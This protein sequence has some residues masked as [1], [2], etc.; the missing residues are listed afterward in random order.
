[1]RSVRRAIAAV[2]AFIC[3]SATA[4]ADSGPVIVIP[5]RG[6]SIEG[7]EG[8]Y[9]AG[10]VVFGDWGLFRPGHIAPRFE[11][12]AVIAGPLR[13]TGW[14]PSSGRRPAIGRHEREPSPDAP[15]PQAAESYRRYWGIGSQ[16]AGPAAT[17]T[18]EGP[19]VIVAPSEV[20]H[21]RPHPPAPVPIKP[22]V[23][24]P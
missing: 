15:K 14:Y 10:A 16:D 17:N 8:G 7:L 18:Q 23:K 13:G 6:A 20:H 3:L 12:P 21:A 9:A 19:T 22:P 1:M 24:H 5:G 4:S 11:G 2:A